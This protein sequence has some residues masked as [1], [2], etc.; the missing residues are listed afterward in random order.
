SRG[1]RFL[2]EDVT[3]AHAKEYEEKL[4][5]QFVIASPQKRQEMIV[6]QANELAEKNHWVIDLDEDLLEE[7]N[8][9]VEYPTVFSGDFEEKYL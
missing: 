9:L 2:G 4:N 5:E 8:N 3:F 6:T 7:V 1:H